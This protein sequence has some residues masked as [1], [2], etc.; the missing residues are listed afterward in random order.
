MTSDA[1]LGE[2]FMEAMAGEHGAAAATLD[3]YQ[4]GLDLFLGWLSFMKLTLPVVRHEDI[5]E[6]LGFLARKGYAEGTIVNRCSVMRSLFRF[7]ASDRL[8]DRD[9]TSFMDPIMRR[10]PLPTVLPM[11]EVERLLER[12]NA[13]AEDTEAS[14]FQQA[15]LARRAAL[16]ETLYASGMRV[17]EAIRLPATVV[18]QNERMLTIVGK[19]NKERLVPLHDAARDAIRRWRA[20]AEAYGCVS[21]R[22]LF[23]SVRDGSKP[24]ARQSAYDDIQAAATDAGLARPKLV[25]PHVLRHAFATHLL[26]NGADLRAIQVL[27]GHAD[28]GTT[29]IY[30]HVDLS[31]AHSMVMDLHPLASEE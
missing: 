13:L 1:I 17:S 19:G 26:R 30:T 18:H 29:E 27:L 15:S 23:H 14:L 12:A 9:P 3:S 24:L 5:V 22:W 4:D 20:R 31:R 11:E 16:F 6:Y 25:T 7:L 2:N 10:R 21:P 8:I 28:L